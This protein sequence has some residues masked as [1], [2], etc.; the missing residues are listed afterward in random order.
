MNVFKVKIVL[1]GILI[2]VLAG[3]MIY[4]LSIFTQETVR[5]ESAGPYYFTKINGLKPGSELR[6]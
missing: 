6:L 2:A 4:G 3:F 5:Y 1:G